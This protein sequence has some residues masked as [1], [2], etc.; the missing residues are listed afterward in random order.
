MCLPTIASVEGQLVAE[1]T[2]Y[3]PKLLG[4]WMLLYGGSSFVASVDLQAIEASFGAKLV[5]RTAAVTAAGPDSWGTPTSA[6]T[7][8]GPHANS[9]DVST[10]TDQLLIQAAVAPGLTAGTTPKTAFGRLW[11]SVKGGGVVVA[12]QK[13]V[14]TPSSG[15][16]ILPIGTPF[17][18]AGVT[19]LMFAFLFTGVSGTI[20][21]PACVW[22]SFDSGDPQKPGAWSAAL[23]TLANVTTD[24]AANSGS[25]AVTTTDKLMAQAGFKYSTSGT[26]P[27][28]TVDV[29]VAAKG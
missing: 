14:L 2:T 23:T 15:N 6:F 29:I 26:D 11:C 5:Y 8:A 25:L 22:R 16:L 4:P 1:S 12:R 18:C 28:A 24:T 17:P 13:F 7:T 27:N 21:S 9:F 19:G 20:A 3:Q 10:T